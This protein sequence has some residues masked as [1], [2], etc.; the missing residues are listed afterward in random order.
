M[1]QMIGARF[2][3]LMRY[4]RDWRHN[5]VVLLNKRA[6]PRRLRS[7]VA[8]HELAHALGMGHHRRMGV[9]GRVGGVESLSRAERRALRRE[10]S[11]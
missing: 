2:Y 8:A 7:A 9:L 5:R 3:G 1:R 10:Y 4:P 6:T 11:R